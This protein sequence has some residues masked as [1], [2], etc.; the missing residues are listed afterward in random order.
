M[1]R[2]TR[3]VW[4][5]LAALTAIRLTLIGTVDLAF[6]EA[7]YWMWSERL[8]PGV[9]QQRPRRGLRHLVERR[10]L[11][12][13][14]IWCAFPQS[15]RR[16]GHEPASCIISRAA[17]SATRPDSGRCSALNCLPIFNVGSFV[18]TTDT[19][20]IFFWA[21]AMF[22]FWLALEK[23]PEFTWRW[24]LTG[25]LIGLGFLC[26]YTNALELISIVHGA[27]A[28]AAFAA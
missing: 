11:G 14:R 26:K 1:S 25:L 17:F 4:L 27:R 19:L 16:H 2:T 12:A 18:M 22:C 10:A 23:S 9:F 7:H 5:F 13:N 3:A 21:A 6:D 24:P 8:A 28:R 15:A 20:S